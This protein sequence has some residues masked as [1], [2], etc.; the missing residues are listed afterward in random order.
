V[1]LAGTGLATEKTMRQVGIV[2]RQ[3]PPGDTQSMSYSYPIWGLHIPSQ[4][5]LGSGE[6]DH[7]AGHSPSQCLPPRVE[8]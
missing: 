8:V 1:A 3:K 6:L 2:V 4:I 5:L 7:S